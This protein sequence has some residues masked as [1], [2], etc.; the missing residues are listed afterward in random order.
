MG[1]IEGSRTRKFRPFRPVNRTASH[2]NHCRCVPKDPMYMLLAVPLPAVT[3]KAPATEPGCE[4]APMHTTVPEC[5][6]L[7]SSAPSPEP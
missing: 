4:S 5:I 1:G 7:V 3:P 2:T 6:L